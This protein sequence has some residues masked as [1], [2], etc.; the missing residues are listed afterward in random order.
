MIVYD[1]DKK[2]VQNYHDINS[3]LENLIVRYSAIDSINDYDKWATY[4]IKY[5]YTTQKYLDTKVK[6]EGKGKL[7]CNLSHQLLLHDIIVRESKEEYNTADTNWFLILEDDVGIK[8]HVTAKKFD[9]FL[10]RLIY[11]IEEHAPSTKFIQL[12]IYDQFFA[13]QCASPKIFNVINTFQ[14]IPPY[15]TCAYLIHKDAIHI[16]NKMKPFS[17]N[18]DFIY[19][20]LDSEFKSCA[21]INNIFYCKGSIDSQDHNSELGSL[22]WDATKYN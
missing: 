3:K 14:K 19:N 6:R 22:I 21:T 18:I 10:K 11:D 15:G 2:R 17:D 1:K 20:S 12:C 7:G 8:K 16:V 5:N 13:K 9:R 4:A